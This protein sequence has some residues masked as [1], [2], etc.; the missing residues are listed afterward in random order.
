LKDDAYDTPAAALKK[1]MRIFTIG[2]SNRPIDAFVALL[3]REGINAVADIRKHPGSRHNPQYNAK[4]LTQALDVA[5]ILYRH[6]PALGGMRDKSE[7][8]SPNTHWQ[9]GAFRNYADYAMTSGFRDGLRELMAL[10]ERHTAAIMCA[11]ADWHHCHRRIVTDYLLAAGVDVHHILDSGVEEAAFHDTATIE[12][13]GRIIYPG[14][15]T[16]L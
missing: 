12:P 3:Q 10:A 13:D 1:V 15:P 16:L 11:E 7:E 4:A 2:H 5:G 9:V 14:E 6:I 8:P